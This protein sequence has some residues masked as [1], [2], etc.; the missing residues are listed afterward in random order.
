MADQE[1]YQ[2]PKDQIR[3]CTQHKFLAS[4]VSLLEEPSTQSMPTVVTVSKIAFENKLCIQKARIIP[5]K[6]MDLSVPQWWQKIRQ[7]SR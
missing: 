6:E 7:R 5:P 4:Q 2:P 1:Y 3:P